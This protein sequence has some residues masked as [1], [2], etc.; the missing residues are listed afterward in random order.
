MF[1]AALALLLA[2]AGLSAPAAS[3]AA[4]AQPVG[5]TFQAWFTNA[6]TRTLTLAAF[7]LDLGCPNAAGLPQ[8]IP[9]GAR[10]TWAITSCDDIAV[11]GYATYT[12][13]G[14]GGQ[15]YAYLPWHIPSGGGDPLYGT[16]AGGLFALDRSFNELFVRADYTFRCLSPAC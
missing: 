4:P 3:A 7:H 2:W 12:V 8:R 16:Q 13:D 11:V 5:F 9:P 1:G 10:V 6:T 15:G 14:S